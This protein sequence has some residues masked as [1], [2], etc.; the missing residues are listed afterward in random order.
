[1]AFYQGKLYALAD[2]ENLLIINIS[3]DPSTGNPQISR[4]GQVI[5]GDPW[6]SAS[7]PDNWYSAD[8]LQDTMGKKKLYL[9]ESCGALLMVR[10]KVCCS[11]AGEA[12][13]SGQC[14]FE[15]FKADLERSRWVNVTSLGDDQMIFLGRSCS[16]AVTASQYGM[17]GDQIFFLDDVMENCKYSFHEETTSVSVYDMRTGEVSSPLPMIWKHEMILATWLFP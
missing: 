10:R 3:Q 6:E 7:M 1:M 4:I 13:V 17:P 15:V 14:E 2:D 9:V 16:R 8:M 11:V 12:A 5:K